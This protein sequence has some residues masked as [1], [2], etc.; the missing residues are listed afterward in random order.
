VSYAVLGRG[1]RPRRRAAAA[2]ASPTAI[3]ASRTSIHSASDQRLAFPAG[4]VERAGLTGAGMLSSR[5][6][7]ATRG[8]GARNRFSIDGG[9]E[10]ASDRDPAQGG[11]GPTEVGIESQYSLSALSAGFAHPGTA[12]AA[13]LAVALADAGHAHRTTRAMFVRRLTAGSLDRGRC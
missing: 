11:P 5:R 1:R 6:R 12:P 7:A 3:A 4:V 9:S 8:P 13:A 10:P 2:A